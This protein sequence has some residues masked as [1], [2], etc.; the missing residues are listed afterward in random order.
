MVAFVA[1]AA[2]GCAVPDAVPY[3][4]RWKRTPEGGTPLHLAVEK[5]GTVAIRF[6]QPPQGT[7]PEMKGRGIFH[8]DTVSFTGAG[9]EPGTARYQ[10]AVNAA[11][12][13]V[14]PLGTDGCSVRRAA[15]GGV[16]SRE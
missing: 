12:L 9:C 5:T 7:A 14:T 3:S 16:W 8:A 2:T 10:L 4:G 1:I 11:G 6:D 13:T 15:L